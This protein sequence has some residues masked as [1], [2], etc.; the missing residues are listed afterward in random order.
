MTCLRFPRLFTTS[1]HFGTSLHFASLRSLRVTST[2]SDLFELRCSRLRRSRH[3][4]A[5]QPSPTRCFHLACHSVAHTVTTR[6]FSPSEIYFGD[7]RGTD[8]PIDPCALLRHARCLT[9][10]ES[11]LVFALRSSPPP[12]RLRLRFAPVLAPYLL[13]DLVLL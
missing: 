1:A 12:F 3:P 11:L 5:L 13:V 7:L 8:L 9:A 2:N 4:I 10:R 6:A